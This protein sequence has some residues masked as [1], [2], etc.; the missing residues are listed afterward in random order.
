MFEYRH[1][2][3]LGVSRRL[4]D[5]RLRLPA[6]LTPEVMLRQYKSAWWLPYVDVPLHRFGLSLPTDTFERD[7]W[8][9]TSDHAEAGV[10]TLMPNGEVQLRGLCIGDTR[11]MAA[12]RVD[13]ADVSFGAVPGDRPPETTIRGSLRG[14]VERHD[15][16]SFTLTVPF[17]GST[18][19]QWSVKRPWAE[20]LAVPDLA[21]MALLAWL[22]APAALY[23][24]D[25]KHVGARLPEVTLFGEGRPTIDWALLRRMAASLA[26]GGL[27]DPA[28]EGQPLLMTRSHLPTGA[29]RRMAAL[30]MYEAKVGYDTTPRGRGIDV[31]ADT[32]VQRMV[33]A[34][35]AAAD[36]LPPDGSRQVAPVAIHAARAAL[37]T[38]AGMTWGRLYRPGHTVPWAHLATR[39]RDMVA[40]EAGG[41]LWRTEYL[42]V[43]AT[44]DGRYRPT[45]MMGLPFGHGRP[46]GMSEGAARGRHDGA[47]PGPLYG[48]AALGAACAVVLPIGLGAVVVM[49]RRE[50]RA[51]VHTYAGR[52]ALLE[53][54]NILGLE[55]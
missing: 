55:M 44:A 52:D 41:V 29:L 8:Q 13:H 7:G 2:V 22:A 9:D 33:R 11:L 51:H 23:G 28:D 12:V 27:P 16:A 54:M 26:L 35:Q 38:L 5:E 24:P 10:V 14:V 20:H 49:R 6:P 45:Q 48:V 32:P 17:T 42:E 18:R 39:W 34:R 1:D 40:R 46:S 37:A 53:A 15:G 50:G 4:T 3:K 19:R 47:G 30:A 25:V 43:V 31:A 21:S 36:E